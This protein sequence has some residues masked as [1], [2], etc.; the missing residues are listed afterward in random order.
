MPCR[1]RLIASTRS[2]RSAVSVLCW[3][4]ISPQ[5]FLG[6]QVD[7]AEPLAV[8]A[9][10]LQI[11]SM[12]ATSGSS[13]FGSMPASAATAVGL[14]FEHFVDLV[15]DVGEPALG[16]LDALLGARGLLAGGAQRF[17]RGAD[18]AVGGGERVLGF[19]QAVGGFAA[20]RLGG[21]DLGDQRAAL[22]REGGRRVGKRR[23]LAAWLRRCGCR[24]WRS[25]RPRGRGARS[26][27]AGRTPM[28][29]S[30]RSASS[31][32]RASAC[33]SARTSA[34][35]VR[36]PS[37]SVRT[38]ASLLSSSADGGSSASACFGDVATRPWPRRGCRPAGSWLRSAPRCARHCGPSR[39][40]PSPA[41]RGHCRRRAGLRASA[42]RA[43]ASAAPAAV[44][45]ACAA[46]AALRFSSTAVRA[47]TSSPSMSARR[48][49]CARRRAAPVGA[50]ASAAKPSQRHRS[51]SRETSRWPGLSSAASRAPSARST[52]PIWVRRRASSAGACTCLASDSR[53]LRQRRIG[54]IDRGAGPAHRVALVDRRVEIVAERRAKRDLVALLDGDAV[55]HRRPHALGLDRE[56]LHQGLGFGVEPLHRALGVGE[57]EAG[58]VEM[59][60]RRDVGGFGRDRVL[61]GL[62]DRGLRALD[63]GCERRDVRAAFARGG[64][65]RLDVGDLAVHPRDALA[66]L[67]GGLR[68]LVA[69]R[70]EIGELRR[71]VRRRSFRPR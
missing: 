8:A 12:V 15:G 11:R 53:A 13:A 36:L 49:R 19:G 31:A 24:A 44:R 9:Q 51:P 70:G 17:E 29:T 61:F 4:S 32:S 50:W 52:T 30:R 71:S 59:L 67:A 25:A 57:R 60:A 38:A 26:R 5:L 23:A 65:A 14:D 40:R 47:V 48:L 69:A 27:P 58:G 54:R 21:L 3:V 43:A 41:A 45:S 33:A 10:L 39:A 28:A 22:L 34:S 68:Q 2:S 16:A 20:R 6:A 35:S 64:K 63:R 46:S 7:R 62:A 1:S 55:D 56:Q 66:L 18:G 37:I 42:S